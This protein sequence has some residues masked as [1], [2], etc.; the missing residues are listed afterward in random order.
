MKKRC[1]NC[2]VERDVS[3]FHAARKARGL[4]SSRG[5]MGVAAVCKSCRSELR[6]PGITALRETQKELTLRGLKKCNVCE[7]EKP[8]AEFSKRKASKDGLNF[9]CRTCSSARARRWR[10]QNPQA[11]RDWSSENSED[12]ARY[13]RQYRR[14][15]K[16]ALSESY[17]RWAQE[18][19]HIVNALTAKR[20]AAKKNATAAWADHDAIR[21]IY[22]RAAYLSKATGVKHEVDHIYPLQGEFICG[23]HCEDNLQILTKAENIRKHN[24]MPEDLP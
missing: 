3:N 5:G 4:R 9:T 15:N 7:I 1:T 16:D 11:F 14:K 22:E 23:L 12:R 19:K 20:N 10:E 2:G 8:L 6:K 13:G 17:R 18:N 21:E 24:R